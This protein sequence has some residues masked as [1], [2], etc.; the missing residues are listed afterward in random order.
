MSGWAG[1]TRRARLPANWVSLRRQRLQMD[2]Y[3]CQWPVA[4]GV[5]CGV[6]ASD[7][8]H[9]EAMTDDHSLEALQSLCGPH[10]DAKSGSEGGRASGAQAKRKAALKY[11]PREQHPGYL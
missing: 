10:H 1:S 9:R 8:D 2:D 7:V 5:I 4:P 3:R 6:L 11:R